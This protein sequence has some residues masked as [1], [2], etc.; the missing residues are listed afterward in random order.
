MRTL[1]PLVVSLFLFVGCSSTPQKVDRSVHALDE[2][3]NITVIAPREPWTY[4]VMSFSDLG[5]LLGPVEISVNDS[6]EK[7][8]LLTEML[9]R[10]NFKFASE[11]TT[12][13]TDRLTQAGYQ[14]TVQEGSWVQVNDGYRLI[15]GD[16]QTR[17]DAVLVIAPTLMGFVSPPGTQAYLPTVTARV[18]L[19]N[20]DKTLALYQG[21]FATG[22]SPANSLWTFAPATQSFSSFDDVLVSPER[23]VNSLKQASAVIADLAAK[24]ILTS[25]QP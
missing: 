11:L 19:L 22:W 24:Q 18:T 25:P 16:I 8:T 15:F 14:V 21:F 4:S 23:A 3:K 10:K 1:I 9:K 6:K 5:F 7:Q 2:V 17:S 20:K 13:M 12:Q